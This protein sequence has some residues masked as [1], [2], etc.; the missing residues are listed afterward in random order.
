M[1]EKSRKERSEGLVTVGG[2][3]LLS[4]T[5]VCELA[6]EFD[7]ELGNL[8]FLEQLEDGIVSVEVVVD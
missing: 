2:S 1:G 3:V 6:G 7:V 4:G 5:I 8:E